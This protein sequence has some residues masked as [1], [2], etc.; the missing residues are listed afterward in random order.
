MDSTQP[1][2][3]QS[4]CSSRSSRAGGVTLRCR[5]RTRAGYAL[6]HCQACSAYTTV[7]QPTDDELDHA[8]G[9]WYPAGRGTLRPSRRRT[10]APPARGWRVVDQVR[11]D[12]CST[13][14]PGTG[15]GRGAHRPRAHAR[16]RASRHGEHIPAAE[17]ESTASGQLS[18]CGARWNTCSANGSTCCRPA[19]ARGVLIVAAPNPDSLPG[20]RLRAALVRGSAAPPR[21]PSADTLIAGLE[22]RGLNVERQPLARRLTFGWLHGAV[23]AAWSS[24][25][26]D[27]IRVPRPGAAARAVGGSRRSRAAP[28]CGRSLQHVARAK[29]CSDVAGRSTFARHG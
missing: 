29:Q 24:G 4:T 25:S 1:G 14:A 10:V 18:R 2:E 15:P 8:Y 22:A 9:P 27:A 3:A 21:P 6:A 20:T 7:P 12:R 28:Y 11:P 13:L 16:P 19:C 5:S 23:A 17:L 26:A